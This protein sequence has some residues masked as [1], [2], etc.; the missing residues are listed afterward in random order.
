MANTGVS[1]R[2]EKQ[3]FRRLSAVTDSSGWL[4]LDST[5]PGN[6]EKTSK[7][8]IWCGLKAHSLPVGVLLCDGLW[9]LPNETKEICLSAVLQQPN[10]ALPTGDEAMHRS[11]KQTQYQAEALHFT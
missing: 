5:R 3:T 1:L 2:P 7:L 9:E 10:S 8:W 11:S 4:G 6:Y